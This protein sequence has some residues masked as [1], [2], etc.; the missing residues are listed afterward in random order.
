MARKSGPFGCRS[1]E[2]NDHDILIINAI[3]SNAP[4]YVSLDESG[5]GSWLPVYPV[6]V[7]KSL[8]QNTDG[9]GDTLSSIAVAMQLYKDGGVAAFFDGLQ[10]KMIRAGVNHAVTFWVYESC[11]G[12]LPLTK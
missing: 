7:V 1:A 8:V 5:M 10:P 9:K 11:I 2:V 3:C 6:D 4:R 12:A